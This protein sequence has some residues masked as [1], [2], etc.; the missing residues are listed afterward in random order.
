MTG[1]FAEVVV[2]LPIRGRFHYAIPEGMHLEVGHRVLVPFGRRR[3]TGFV[4]DFADAA[5]ADFAGKIKPIEDRLDE[6]PL[7]SPDL[8]G[9][10]AFAA[11]YYLAPQGEVLKTALPPGL[12]AA[13]AVYLKRTDAGTAALE[14]GEVAAALRPLL[15]RAGKAAG[16]KRTPKIRREAAQLQ[17]RGWVRPKDTLA[18][19]TPEQ[20]IEMIE[21]APNAKADAVPARARARQKVFA[22]LHEAQPMSALAAQFGADA[23]RRAVRA[24]EADALVVRRRV[25]QAQGQSPAPPRVEDWDVTLSEAQRDAL[26][27]IVEALNGGKPQAFLLRGVTGSG[28]T[29]VYLHAIAEARRL[30]RSAIVLVPEIALTSQLESR[31]RARFG[32]DV[33]VLHSAM[34]DKTRRTRWDRLHRGAAHIAL[35]PRSAVW[36]PVREPGIIVV[37]EEHD[38]SFKQHTELRYNGRDLALLRANRAGGVAVLGSATPSLETRH[39]A[40]LGRVHE[41]RLAERIEGRPMPAV[42]LV[43]LTLAPRDLQGELPIISAELSDALYEVVAQREQAILFLNRRGFNTVVVCDDC[44][45]SRKCGACDVSLTY[46]KARG[47]LVCHY[48]GHTER[49]Q[50]RCADCNGA[51]MKPFGAGTERIATAVREAVPDARVLRLDR[52]V[53][54]KV[55][56]LDATLDAFRTG[57]ADVLVGTQMVTKGHDFPNVTLVG[58]LCADSSLAF[59]DFRAA[60]RTFQLMTQVAGRA[61]RADKPGRVIVQAFQPDH[62]S[63]TCAMTHDDNRFFDIEYRSRR[64]AGYPP[65]SRMGVVRIESEDEALCAEVARDVARL[66]RIEAKGGAGRVRGP[67]AAPIERIRNRLRRMVMILA[68]SPAR[69]VA[70]MGRVQEGLGS[71]PAKVAVV[72]DVDAFDLL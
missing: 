52:D 49:L 13:S 26:A 67:S 20:V 24:L 2:T 39:L 35:G 36:A 44:G 25:I 32:D 63:L 12:T 7:L 38:S 41:L 5:P 17:K 56:A 43:D 50:Q 11:D 46:H 47:E 71:P 54:A 34:T 69:L 45:A 66:A 53:T 55:G 19:K 3:V 51:T 62:Y 22:A 10:V 48:C 42:K 29:E 72:F 27:A 30:G 68:P 61:G 15:E 59:P 60:E 65:F 58:I 40:K 14:A 1:R 57:E 18:A 33:V 23:A 6:Q 31:F 70:L 9:I 28:K 4:I 64:S 21:R 37:D 16:L 8:L